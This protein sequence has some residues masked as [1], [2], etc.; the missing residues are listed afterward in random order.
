MPP[1]SSARLRR[2]LT[3][4]YRCTDVPA[5]VGTVCLLACLPCRRESSWHAYDDASKSCGRRP[6]R[7]LD[8]PSSRCPSILATGGGMAAA[9]ADLF[10]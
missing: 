7:C 6:V 5:V 10:A 4:R 1:P 2:K 3:S 8:Q 9:D